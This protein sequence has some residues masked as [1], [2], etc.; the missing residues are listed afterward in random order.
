MQGSLKKWLVQKREHGLLESPTG[1]GKTLCLLSAVLAWREAYAALQCLEDQKINQDIAINKD[2]EQE[3]A[4]RAAVG[5]YTPTSILPLS[6]SSINRIQMDEK[7]RQRTLPPILYASRTH[8]QLAQAMKEL[9][10]MP[11]A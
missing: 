9:Q 10:R 1:T 2:E 8:S 7:K 3:R 11:Y 4:L 6:S 5:A